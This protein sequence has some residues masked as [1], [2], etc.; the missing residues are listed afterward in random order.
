MGV[1]RHLDVHVFDHNTAGPK[2]A[3]VRDLGATYH[4]DAG[5]L[6]RLAPDILMECSGVPAVIRD[7]LGATAPSGIICLVGVTQPHKI[8]DS[9]SAV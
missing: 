8:F 4:S 7:C 2:P 1:Q 9:M 5:S 6:G 3:L